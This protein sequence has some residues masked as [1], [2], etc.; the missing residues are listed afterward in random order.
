[1]PIKLYGTATSTCS[2][3]VLT[4]LIEKGLKYELIPVDFAAGEQKVKLIFKM[5]FF[6]KDNLQIYVYVECQISRRKT[7][8]WCCSCTY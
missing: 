7:T 8:I 1:M 3:R 2:Q 5:L 6:K 4:T